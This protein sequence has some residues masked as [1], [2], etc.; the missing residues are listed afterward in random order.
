MPYCKIL[1]TVTAVITSPTF[2][3]ISTS[4][5]PS[6]KTPPFTI[7]I[8]YCFVFGHVVFTI[9]GVFVRLWRRRPQPGG[10]E[11]PSKWHGVGTLSAF[12]VVFW[13]SATN[14]KGGDRGRT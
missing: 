10:P 2:L 11:G 9:L 7:H 14:V 8:A 1:M 12:I 13:R 6:H 3:R 5:T 4:P